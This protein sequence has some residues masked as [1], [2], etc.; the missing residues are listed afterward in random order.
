MCESSAATTQ[1]MDC[2]ADGTGARLES[3]V[4]NLIGQ[5][6]LRWIFVGGKGGV[7]KTTCSCG[8][9]IQLARVRSSVL[10]ISTDPAHNVSD[11]FN[12]KF[13]KTPSRVLGFENL[14]AME[15]DPNL[16][17]SQLPEDFFQDQD[18]P[19][20]MGKA[21]M[22]ELVGAFPG[23]DEAMSFAEVMKLIQKMNFDVVVFDTAPTGHTLRLL[24]FPS[25]VEKGL[26]KLLK[27]KN[28]FTPLIRNISSF[29][30]LPDA[31]GDEAT[32]KLEAALPT[33]RRVNEQFR[34]AEQT[35]FVCVCIAEFLSLYETE[36]LVQELAKQGIDTHNI[37]V[38]QL[39]FP[40]QAA[41]EPCKTCSARRKIQ[42][43]YLDQI[44]D[45][46]E[47]FHITQLPLL[48]QEVRGVEQLTAFSQNLITPYSS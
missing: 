4:G 17:M 28:T 38:N 42:H 6:S 23:I 18:D 7:G 16:G 1:K 2:D 21:V 24:Q 30:G 46:Y 11:A 37:L 44:E 12:Q 48:D 41:K 27:I 25:I 8:V 43:K 5:R 22:E 33:I 32:E 45:L 19:I 36:R 35:S 40:E 10:I 31:S 20:S 47:D 26:G 3:S 29:L 9:A 15:V 39:V 34:N 14:F 13:G